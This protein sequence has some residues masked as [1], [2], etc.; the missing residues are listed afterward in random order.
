MKRC[1]IRGRWRSDIRMAG[2]GRGR[3]RGTVSLAEQTVADGHAGL[4][5][6]NETVFVVTGA[7]GSIVSAITSDLAAAS[8]GTFYLLDLVPEPDANNPD[9]KRLTRD[10]VG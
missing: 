5:L 7:A 8:G 3:W 9:L 10:R 6:D 4:S 1:E 2:G